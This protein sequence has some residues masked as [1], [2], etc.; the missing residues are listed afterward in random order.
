MLINGTDLARLLSVSVRTIRRLDASGQL[1][2]PVRIQGCVRWKYDD[3]CSWVEAGCP[4]RA[5][6]ESIQ[7]TQLNKGQNK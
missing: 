5:K 6:W 7:A 3:I 4:A 2:K 1:P